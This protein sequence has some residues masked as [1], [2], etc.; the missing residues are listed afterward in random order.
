VPTGVP[1]PVTAGFKSQQNCSV[2]G[3]A[4]QQKQDV[5][6]A[7]Q[8]T[9]KAAEAGYVPAQSGVAMTYANGKGVQPNYAETGN[10]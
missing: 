8:F 6:S 1:H 7:F 3:Y 10:W 5:A 4:T 2:L 9:L